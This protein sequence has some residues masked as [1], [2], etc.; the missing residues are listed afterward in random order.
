MSVETSAYLSYGLI[1]TLE[2]IASLRELLPEDKR[3][4]LS[5]ANVAQGS[6]IFNEVLEAIHSIL[7]ESLSV[8]VSQDQWSD[9]FEAALIINARSTLQKIDFKYSPFS[10]LPV[11]SLAQPLEEELR[12]FEMFKNPDG[13]TRQPEL[14]VWGAVY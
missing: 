13:T 14:L 12:A 2:D 3:S 11:R 5:P 8:D 9:S 10:A 4:I 7:P 6:L 1:F